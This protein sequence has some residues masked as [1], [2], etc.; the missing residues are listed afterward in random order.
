MLTAAS[1]IRDVLEFWFSADC[2]RHW[3]EKDAEFDVRVRTRLLPLHE[4]A[5]AGGLADWRQSPSG[6]VALCVLLDQVPRNLFRGTSRA[7]ACD[8][9]AR[10]VTRH[11]LAQD[12]DRACSQ[13]ERL[14]LY[15]PLEH[16]ES[17]D[18]QR[19]SVTLMG[20]L[21]DTP[22]WLDHAERH[23]DIVR[24]FGRFPHRNTALG[25]DSSAEE[26]AFLE[27]PNSSF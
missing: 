6:C 16:S 23:Y 25:R 15:L 10:E 1:T 4:R 13:K 17:L 5:A 19:L 12:F 14:F 26:L 21:D 7:F 20:Q 3:F 11:A 27:T 24:R 22:E 9:L 18:D 2:E 8:P